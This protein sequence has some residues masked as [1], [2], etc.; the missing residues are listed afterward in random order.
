MKKNSPID[1]DDCL[2]KSI[3]DKTITQKEADV[4]VNYC[5]EYGESYWELHW[6][7]IEEQNGM[8]ESEADAFKRFY[9]K[10]KKHEV[11]DDDFQWILF[12]CSVYS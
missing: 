4:I 11:K 12:D 6:D 3:K 1:L 5:K 10:F 8:S 7:D 2:T 9:L